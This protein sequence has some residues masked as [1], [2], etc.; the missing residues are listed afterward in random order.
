MCCSFTISLKAYQRQIRK[1]SLDTDASEQSAVHEVIA[2]GAE[3]CL[4]GRQK[5]RQ[6]SDLFGCA[7]APERMSRAKTCEHFFRRQI[8]RRSVPRSVPAWVC[9]SNLG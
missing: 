8:R 3:S 7:D 5:R 9:G 4:V 1:R 6:F 2:S